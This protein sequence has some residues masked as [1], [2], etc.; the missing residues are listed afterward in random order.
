MTVFSPPTRFLRCYYITPYI[1]LLTHLEGEASPLNTNTNKN[2]FNTKRN[3]KNQFVEVV[4]TTKI[5]VLDETDRLLQEG[6]H[7]RD[8]IRLLQTYIGTR[9]GDQK[10]Q[11]LL[12]SATFPRPVRRLLLDK[13]SS[14]FVRNKDKN[15]NSNND[16]HDFLEIDCIQDDNTINT[17]NNSGRN[18]MSLYSTTPTGSDAHTSIENSP[19][20]EQQ[21]VEEAYVLLQNMT[22]YVTVLLTV[23]RREQERNPHNYK[24]LVFFPAGR[25]VRFMYQLFTTMTTGE[26]GGPQTLLGKHTTTME[27]GEIHSRMSQ[28][29][30]TRASAAFRTARRGLLLTTDVSARGLDYPDVSLV[31]QLGAPVQTRDYIHRIG[32]TG[33]AGNTGRGVLVLLPFEHNRIKPGQQQQRN[34]SRSN[35]R[36][37]GDNRRKRISRTPRQRNNTNYL[38][39]D[40]IKNDEE[41]TSWLQAATPNEE[42]EEGIDCIDTDTASTSLSTTTSLFQQCQRDVNA[43]QRKITSNS[44]SSGNHSHSLTASA[45]AA[46]KT[47]LAHYCLVHSSS[48]ASSTAGSSTTTTKQKKKSTIIISERSK[49]IVLPHAQDFAKGIGLASIPDD[50]FFQQK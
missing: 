17:N 2:N 13:N 15:G 39:T 16:K 41:L 43:I 14:T 21:R 46:Y 24:I 48:S 29:S 18:R 27:V 26:G 28:A 7:K 31:V 8:T 5:V 9:L 6:S 1:G 32:R 12:F 25:L 10:R 11:V 22:Q 4:R 47:F 34:I 3:Q 40:R 45:E 42:N 36:R 35:G 19:Q 30:R 20:Q 33:R 37:D 23:F 38:N 49:E 44:S 50:E